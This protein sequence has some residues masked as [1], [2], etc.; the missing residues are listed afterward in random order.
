MNEEQQKLV[1]LARIGR[2]YGIKGW[3][4]LTSYTDPQDNI[5]DFKRLFA[6]I[7]GKV[8]LLEMDQC[9]V[10]GKGLIA[11]FVGYDDPDLAKGLTGI[12][13]TVPE[14]DLPKLSSEDFY[15]YEL[16]GMRVETEAGQWLGRVEKLLETGAN[17]VLVVEPQDGSLDDRERLIP[18]LPDRVVTHVSR[19]N[20][21]I[22]V[23]WDPDYLA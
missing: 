2:L 11:H 7:G 18:Y 20:R 19:E 13:L 15:W 14:E 21:C 9:K 22:K 4:K 12:E 16:T 6:R 10:H 17:D 5:L 3:L 23:D 1:T 8:Q